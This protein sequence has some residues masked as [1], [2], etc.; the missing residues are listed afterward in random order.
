[1]KILTQ[2]KFYLVVVSLAFITLLVLYMN[3]KN[4]LLK[5][6]TDLHYIPGGDI[7]KAELLNQNDSLRNEMFTKDIELGSY[8]YMWEILEEVNKPL[9][10]SINLQVE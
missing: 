3:Q 1:M 7:E 9:A 5:Y 8:R 4:E 2:V 6:Q 10:D